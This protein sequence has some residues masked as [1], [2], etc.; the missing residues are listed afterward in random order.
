MDRLGGMDV[1]LDLAKEKAR[2]GRDQEVNLVILPE[3]KGFLETIL[4]RQEDGMEATMA[5]LPLD[6][7]HLL[8]WMM[9]VTRVRAKGATAFAVIWARARSI[10]VTRVRPNRPALALA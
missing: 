10:A 1:A 9:S 8:R 7:R 3:R 6:V 4:E 5:A 2:I